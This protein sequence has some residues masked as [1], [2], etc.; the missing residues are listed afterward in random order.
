MSSSV[1]LLCRIRTAR[2]PGNICHSRCADVPLHRLQV[3]AQFLTLHLR[4]QRTPWRHQMSY[5]F[6]FFCLL[7]TTTKRRVETLQDSLIAKYDRSDLGA[8]VVR[9]RESWGHV[10]REHSFCKAVSGGNDTVISTLPFKDII[11]FHLHNLH[12]LK[13]EKKRETSNY[14]ERIPD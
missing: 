11:A 4:S 2:S 14:Q 5:F 9:A 8:Q 13:K 10:C 6:F 3:H 12:N 7:H 1:R